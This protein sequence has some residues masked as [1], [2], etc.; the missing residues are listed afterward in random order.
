MKTGYVL[1]HKVKI[2]GPVLFELLLIVRE[3]DTRE[4][5]DQC[6]E[7]DVDHI[8][9][10][11]RQRYTP[12]GTGTGDA[13]ILKVPVKKADDLFLYDFRSNEIRVF[14]NVIQQKLMV[15]RQAEKIVFFLDPICLQLVSGAQSHIQFILI[16]EPLA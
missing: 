1:P 8:P 9:L 7:P 3:T 10:V 4:V 6:V 12:S 2:S 15:I 13:Y 5:I 11:D 16:I 14:L